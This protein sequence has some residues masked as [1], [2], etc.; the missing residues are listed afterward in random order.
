M[1]TGQDSILNPTVAAALV[2]AAVAMLVR[3]VDD[4]LNRRRAR[5][6]RAERISDVQRA[7]LAEIRAH[8][9]ALES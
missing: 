1:A 2:A 7:L 6:L 5:A 9:V 3:P 8:V 4:W